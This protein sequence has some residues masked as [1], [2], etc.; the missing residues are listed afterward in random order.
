[1]KTPTS[2]AALVAILVHLKHR[3]PILEPRPDDECTA[4]AKRGDVI[5]ASPC[6]KLGWGGNT[7][8]DRLR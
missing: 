2:A 7:G 5:K 1:M 6:I 8:L 4:C 3:Y